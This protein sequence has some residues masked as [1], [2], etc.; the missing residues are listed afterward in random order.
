M[1]HRLRFIVNGDPAETW[2]EPNLTLLEVL[3]D[4]LMLT[5]TKEGCGTG[6][7]GA[8]TVLVGGDLVCSCL[9][10]ALEVDGQ[11]VQT[12]EGLDAGGELHPLQKAFI[13]EGGLQCGFCT[14]GMLMSS[15][16]LLERIPRPNEAE[17]RE[18][19]SG[20][21]CRC[22]GYDKIVRAVQSAAME[23][24]DARL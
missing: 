4:Q 2:I 15:L 11:N 16:A 17:I 21:L 24:E 14:P 13:A 6:D 22:T 19:L 20:N 12:V 9:L 3:R 23:L 7:C 10:L 8:C 18:A 5:G 1:K